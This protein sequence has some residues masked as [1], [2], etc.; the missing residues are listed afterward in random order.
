MAR[1]AKTRG[2]EL[3]DDLRKAHTPKKEKRTYSKIDKKGNSR[4]KQGP[5]IKSPS[6]L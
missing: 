5:R 6:K 3:Y 1:S 2:E 4:K